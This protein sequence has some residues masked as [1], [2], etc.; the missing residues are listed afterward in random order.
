MSKVFKDLVIEWGGAEYS[1]EADRRFD[2]ICR[3]EEHVA[4]GDLAAMAMDP[5]RMRATT[6]ARG[7][8]AV[9]RFVGVTEVRGGKTIPIT[10]EGV[11]GIIF[12]GGADAGKSM[13]AISTLMAIIEPDGVAPAAEATQPVK[14]NGNG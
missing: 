1:V 8:A 3:L 10:G 11:Y 12:G 4:I 7:F 9:L 6:L 13:A 5:A 2:L 14:P